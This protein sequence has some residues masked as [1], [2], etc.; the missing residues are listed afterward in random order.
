MA[1]PIA[2]LMMACTYNMRAATHQSWLAT[3]SVSTAGQ[4]WSGAPEAIA[5]CPHHL[6]QVNIV[7][8]LSNMV[9]AGSHCKRYV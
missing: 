6:S 1:V 8:D 5:S 4:V 9:W 7:M 3:L 2:S